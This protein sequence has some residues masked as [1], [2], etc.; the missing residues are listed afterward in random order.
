MENF[1]NKELLDS[2]NKELENLICPIS[3]SIMKHPVITASGHTYDKDSIIQWF[4]NKNTD[5]ITNQIVNTRIL[6]SNYN[7]QSSINAF[8]D[9]VSLKKGDEWKNIQNICRIYKIEKEK[10]E[11]NKK[12]KEKMSNEMELKP[13][14]LIE[15]IQTTDDRIREHRKQGRNQFE[16][17]VFINA[18]APSDISYK[19]I[20][21]ILNEL[22]SKKK[23][24]YEDA[25]NLLLYLYH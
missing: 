4:Q 8:I 17:T 19:T 24:S 12:N 20:K 11:E 23:S 14:E 10:E 5:P 25:M 21:Y 16:L 6:I 1:I 2:A 22:E 7:L 13:I 3:G 15:K 9:K 18:N